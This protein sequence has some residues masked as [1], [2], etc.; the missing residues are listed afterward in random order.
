MWRL[1]L[2]LL[3]AISALGCAGRHVDAQLPN[4]TVPRSD[5][6][7]DPVLVHCDFNFNPPRCK[8]IRLYYKKGSEVIHLP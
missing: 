2:L 3:L 8:G 6:T 4:A 7:E 5:L 1:T